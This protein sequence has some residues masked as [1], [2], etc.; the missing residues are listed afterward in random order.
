MLAG[1]LLGVGLGAA[2][3]AECGDYTCPVVSGVLGSGTGLIVGG[4]IGAAT[5]PDRWEEVPLRRQPSGSGMVRHE[6]TTRVGLTIS[7]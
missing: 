2:V 7:L 4:V 5:A 1:A 6:P 3:G